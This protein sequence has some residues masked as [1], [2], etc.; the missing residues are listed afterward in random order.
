LWPDCRLGYSIIAGVTIGETPPALA[1]EFSCLQEEITQRYNLAELAAVPRIGAVRRMYKK[2]TFDPSRYRP[3]SEAMVRRILQGK[4]LYCVNSAVDVNNYCSVKFLLPM[5]LYDLGRI[6]GDVRYLVAAS[7]TYTNIAGNSVSTD[8]K[9]FL[10]DELGVFGNPTADSQRTAVT[11]D[12]DKLLS[13][14]YPDSEIDSQ[15]LEAIVNFTASMLKSYNGGTIAAA[16]IIEGN[17]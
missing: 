5:G 3:A 14:I 7:G 9:P 15:E 2:L 6:H 13:V 1:E 4:G 12:T 10:A 8:G 17:R 16:G 11:M